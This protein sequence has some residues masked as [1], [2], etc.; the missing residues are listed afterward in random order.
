MAVCKRATLRVKGINKKDAHDLRNTISQWS[1]VTVHPKLYIGPSPQNQLFCNNGRSHSHHQR[2]VAGLD[3]TLSGYFHILGIF[4]IAAVWDLFDC[5]MMM[6][7]YIRRELVKHFSQHGTRRLMSP[8]A[9]KYF[10]LR[11]SLCTRP[12]TVWV[13]EVTSSDMHTVTQT[14]KHMQL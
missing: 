7:D 11:V 4:R 13:P 8:E 6:M 10:Q 14:H 5:L 2:A 3:N 12:Q 9:R 1:T